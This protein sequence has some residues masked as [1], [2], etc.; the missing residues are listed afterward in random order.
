MSNLKAINTQLEKARNVKDIFTMDFVAER[1]VKNYE[2]AT[3]RKDGQNWFQREVLAMMTIFG[4]KPDYGKAD[5]M[6]IWGCLMTAARKGLSIAEGDIDLVPY[7]KGAILKAEPNYKGLRKQLR[8]MPSI[9]FVYE[10][11]VVFDG[12]DFE[13]DKLNNRVIKHI[14]KE[15]P[16]K[17]ELGNIKAAYVRIEFTD[18]KIV[19]VV[20]YQHELIAAKNKTKNPSSDGPWVQFTGEM[21]KKTVLKR[22]HKAYYNGTDY[23]IE[24][25][26]FKEVKQESISN[27]ASDAEDAE[28]VQEEVVAES[29]QGE[30][31]AAPAPEPVKVKRV[32][33]MDDLLNSDE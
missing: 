18:G 24:D 28:V 23:E 12:D 20:M 25:T 32:N 30:P 17:A 26:E 29:E 21:C 4:E 1:S 31:V 27:K 14:S 8:R 33:K 10:A 19:D 22:A 9:K 3:G 13:H 6:S 5:K 11:Q 15:A 7:N 2:M 16:K